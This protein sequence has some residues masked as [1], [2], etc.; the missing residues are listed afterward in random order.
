M[1]SIEVLIIRALVVEKSYKQRERHH[2]IKAAMP[3]LRCGVRRKQ[4]VLSSRVGWQRG[5]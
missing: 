2:P 3:G 4:R 5:Y 1:P